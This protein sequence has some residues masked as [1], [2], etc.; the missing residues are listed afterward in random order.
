MGGGF[1]LLRIQAKDGLYYWIKATSGPNEHE[2]HVTKLIAEFAKD[3]V[4]RI[5]A[6]RDDWNAW[7]MEDA[8]RD[9]EV[10]GHSI[11][12]IPTSHIAV[13]AL[14]NLQAASQARLQD[15]LKVGAFDQRPAMSEVV[16]RELFDYLNECMALQ[17]SQKVA[18]LDRSA[19]ERTRETYLSVCGQLNA[20][21]I[22]LTL[23]HGD[24]TA[25]NVICFGE[26]CRF[27]DWCEAYVGYSI[28]SF[29]HLWMLFERKGVDKP[30]LA[31]MIN[32]YC[33]EWKQWSGRELPQEAIWWSPLMAAA[34]TLYGRG[35]WLHN[36]GQR[37]RPA[38]RSYSRTL[39]RHM[40]RAAQLVREGDALCV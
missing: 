38:R 28:S 25:G 30:Q 22:P 4:P 19:L 29:H 36:Q 24:L 26:Q 18:P 40:A 9:T 17:A 13:T 16:S 23:L 6:S 12:R 21:E 33:S 1:I 8:S 31:S 37:E 32:H 34:S 2:Y 10:A 27:L 35:E 15:L 39:A 20:L 7:L 11:G 14:V 5:V 3:T